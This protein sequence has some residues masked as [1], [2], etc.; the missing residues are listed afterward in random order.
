MLR[1][2]CLGVRSHPALALSWG[3]AAAQPESE[4]DRVMGHVRDR[5]VT[6]LVMPP[7]GFFGTCLSW[8]AWAWLPMATGWRWSTIP[9]AITTPCLSAR[10][11]SGLAACRAGRA[12]AGAVRPLRAG[13]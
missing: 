10:A 5:G 13:M 12:A 4:P 7:S 6:P 1:F 9:R 11:G 3:R 2:A 8:A